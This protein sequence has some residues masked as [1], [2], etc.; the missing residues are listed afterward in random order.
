MA[1]LIELRQRLLR[2][3]LVVLLI[4]LALFPF[5]NTL[6]NAVALPLLQALPAGGTMI[7][8]EVASPFFAP[9]KFAIVLAFALA[10]PYL[11]HQTW[12]FIAPGLYLRE[13]RI[14]MPLLVS[15]IVLFYAGMAFAY[16]VVFP[17]VFGF[18]VSTAPQGVAMMTDI[19]KY[20]DFVLTMF[21]AFG[22]AFEV[23][24]ATIILI[25]AGIATPESLAAKRPYIIVGAFVLGM[26]LTPPDMFS[27][28]LLA[29]PMWLLFEVGLLLSRKFV[30]KG[31]E[32]AAQSEPVDSARRE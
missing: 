7:A 16:F 12:R 29:L 17:L 5:A 28:A 18:L 20:L 25:W 1:H 11:L 4:F 15:S 27:Q 14:A 22:L 32:A 10:M 2:I 31:D 19:A 21:F 6:Y 9:F 30:P 26:M 24:V 3:V 8:T 23:P 13:R